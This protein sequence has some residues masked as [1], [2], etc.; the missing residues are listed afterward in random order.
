LPQ[1]AAYYAPPDYVSHHQ[2]SSDTISHPCLQL[3]TGLAYIHSKGIVHRDLKVLFL[4]F[5]LD[6]RTNRYY[7]AFRL[8]TLDALTFRRCGVQPKN[9]FLDFSGDIK[10]GDLGLARF[11]RVLP[12]R[13]ARYLVVELVTKDGLLDHIITHSYC[14]SAA[15][16]MV[17]TSSA[18]AAS[19]AR[20]RTTGTTTAPQ[21]CP[22][23][24]RSSPRSPPAAS[25][26]PM[27]SLA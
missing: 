21:P 16:Q 15:A 5:H 18:R 17:L 4:C 14:G 19:G 20:T 12:R 2:I 3:V 8:S 6:Q 9:I 13:S 26:T 23:P 27:H 22:R 7:Q 25:G 10:I 11:R 24:S 1:R